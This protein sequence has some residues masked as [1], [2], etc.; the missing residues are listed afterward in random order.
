MNPACL[1]SEF[2]SSSSLRLLCMPPGISNRN[3]FQQRHQLVPH[4]FL[5]SLSSDLPPWQA[6]PVRAKSATPKPGGAP[7]PFT[8]GRVWDPSS[9]LENPSPQGGDYRR[10]CVLQLPTKP[11]V[12]SSQIPMDPQSP[13]V[14]TENTNAGPLLPHQDPNSI[15][16]RKRIQKPAFKRHPGSSHQGIHR[17]ALNRPG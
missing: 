7:A 5:G 13:V 9:S 2:L 12:R 10:W 4:L 17:S 16:K 6:I 15:C 8:K 14:S 11:K 3:E 1:R